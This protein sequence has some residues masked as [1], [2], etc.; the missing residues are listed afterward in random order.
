MTSYSVLSLPGVDFV[1]G[2]A[3]PP[4]MEARPLA[5]I[6]AT[7]EEFCAR[8][9][10][11]QFPFAQRAWGG[12][13]HSLC[14]YQGK[15]KPAI[16]Y[17]LVRNF[18]KPGDRVLDP[19]CGVGTIP[20]EA[21]RQGRVGVGN[22]LSPLAATVSRAKLEPFGAPEVWH[23]VAALS[24]AI[25]RG[26]D[27]DEL[28][29]AVDVDFG[30]NGPIRNYY[31][32]DT[33]RELLIAR[34][35]WKARRTD[36]AGDVADAVVFTSLLHILHGNR[37]YALSRRSHPVTPFA[38]TGPTPYKPLIAGLTRRLERVLPVMQALQEN[39]LPGAVYE[40]DFRQVDCAPVDAVIT[41]P[42]F[43]HSVRF[44]SS[45]WLRLWLCGWDPSDFKS[46]PLAYL[47]SQQRLAFKPYEEFGAACARHLRPKGLLIMH[48][49]ET[50]RMSMSREIMPYLEQ[51]FAI[52]HLGR[53]LVTDTESH[54]LRDKGATIAHEYLVAVRR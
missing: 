19:L 41:S 49:G 36:S 43:A 42:P 34:M 44:W 18:T 54:G 31:H 35:Y 4:V 21:R 40:Q 38:P 37:P 51:N 30:I 52:I 12:P 53:E 15:L 26:P 7:A 33:L 28:I 47:E 16:A 8:A 45:N 50:A 9:P 39:S 46:S 29:S 32:D 1:D 3:E 25:R 23:T 11:R 24:E 22:D 6:R 10:H 48:L 5:G 13:L 2:E 17:F 14:S 20:L 27:L